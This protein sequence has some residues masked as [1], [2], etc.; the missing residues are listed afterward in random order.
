MTIV[1]KIVP[2]REDGR[3][4]WCAE[5]APYRAGYG[6]D[7]GKAIENFF[8]KNPNLGIAIRVSA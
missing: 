7:Q 6:N 5:L 3:T 2:D 4:L 8:E 1:I